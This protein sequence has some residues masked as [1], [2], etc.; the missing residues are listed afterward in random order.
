[1]AKKD[2]K[3]RSMPKGATKKAAR[4]GTSTGPLTLPK[5]F[6][7]MN[8]SKFP[9]PD[10]ERSIFDILPYEITD[11][12]HPDVVAG[13]VEVGDI[14]YRRPYKQ[15]RDIGADNR[16]R[17]C[18]RSIGKSCPICDHRSELMKDADAE[19]NVVE[20][21]R[22]KDRD[23]YNPRPKNGK[24]KDERCVYDQSFHLFQKKLDAELQ[25]PDNEE[26]EDFANL[27]GGA[28]LKVRW[29][30]RTWGKATFY[31]AD[32]VDLKSRKEDYD[33][34]IL[35]EVC[36]LD[37][38]INDNI[39][40]YE[41]LQNEFF[42]MNDGPA[43]S[44]SEKTDDDH[45][46]QRKSADKPEEDPEPEKEGLTYPKTWKQLNKMEEDELVALAIALDNKEKKVKKLDEDELKELIADDLEIKIPKKE[47]PEPEPKKEEKPKP[48][49]KKKDK[50]KPE[51]PHGHNWGGADDHKECDDCD[52][53]DDCIA[54][55]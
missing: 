44:E 5:G 40:S 38:V 10:K 8:E 54:A 33:E 18:R 26:F 51:C 53:W 37:K 21:L 34:D 9:D 39:L 43:E 50:D 35:D 13:L 3:K 6:Q 17:I 22:A 42:E 46:R 31:E 49:G 45:S 32:K 30:E 52:K 19:E 55:A 47:E 14:W 29:A 28:S 36:D 23:L 2:R 27:E 1:M 24:Q 7:F 16:K 20:A 15:H 4:K 25:D 48:S 12:K 41:Q 11:P